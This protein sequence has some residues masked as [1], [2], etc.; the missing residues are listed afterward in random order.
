MRGD[1][2][3]SGIR[4]EQCLDT[5][6]NIAG[7]LEKALQVSQGNLPMVDGLS[8]QEIPLHS[9]PP[10]LL[11]WLKPLGTARKAHYA[12]PREMSPADS[13]SKVAKVITVSVKAAP[14]ILG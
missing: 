13:I 6:L 9:L 12:F 4:A 7:L 14:E 10:S 5:L 3:D 8:Y 1:E 11:P 2:V